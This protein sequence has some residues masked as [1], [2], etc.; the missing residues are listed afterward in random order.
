MCQSTGRGALDHGGCD[1]SNGE[2]ADDMY[3]IFWEK[4]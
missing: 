1:E 4:M 2:S 3:E